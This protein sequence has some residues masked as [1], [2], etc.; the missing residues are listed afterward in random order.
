MVRDYQSRH[1]HLSMDNDGQ[2]V[3]HIYYKY[4]NVENDLFEL[5]HTQGRVVPH[6]T[7]RA[8]A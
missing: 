4:C 1:N 2:S 6:R 5:L 8:S 3:Q 7:I